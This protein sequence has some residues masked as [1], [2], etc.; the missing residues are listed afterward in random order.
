MPHLRYLVA[1]SGLTVVN[2]G[3]LGRKR[4]YVKAFPAV[5]NVVQRFIS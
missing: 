5:G 1:P 4:Q 2:K 3:I